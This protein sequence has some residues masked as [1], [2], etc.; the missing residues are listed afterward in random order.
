LVVKCSFQVEI[1][2][3]PY[4]KISTFFVGFFLAGC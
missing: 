4:A 2:R 1:A 3:F